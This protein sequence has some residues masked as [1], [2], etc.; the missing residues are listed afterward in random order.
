MRI[1]TRCG[2]ECLFHFSLHAHAPWLVLSLVLQVLTLV[3]LCALYLAERNTVDNVCERLALAERY[4]VR[5]LK[6]C[7]RSMSYPCFRRGD[8][9]LLHAHRSA[10]GGLWAPACSGRSKWAR[11]RRLRACARMWW[12]MQCFVVAAR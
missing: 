4:G 10:A 2:F 8:R 7:V 6:V 3:E 1:A 5:S 11:A 9:L 12:V